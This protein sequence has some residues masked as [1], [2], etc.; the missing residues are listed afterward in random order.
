MGIILVPVAK[1]VL[2]KKVLEKVLIIVKR[3]GMFIVPKLE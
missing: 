2:R 1:V 3:K